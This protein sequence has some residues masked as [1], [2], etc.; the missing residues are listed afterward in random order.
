[1][2]NQVCNA[3]G[4]ENMMVETELGWVTVAS[5][6]CF[7]CGGFGHLKQNC[8]SKPQQQNGGKGGG[9]AGDGKGFGKGGGGYDGGKGFGKGGKGGGKGIKGN[10]WN[11]G[12]PGHRSNECRSAKV[13]L[14]EQEQSEEQVVECGGVTWD[15]CAVERKEIAPTIVF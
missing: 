4:N 12:K 1:M 8:P 14:V 7:N 6:K 9:K 3:D 15:V 10:C 11:C 13:N 5:G 2:Q